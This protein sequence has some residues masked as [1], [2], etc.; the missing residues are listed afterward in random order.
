MAE[1]ERRSSCQLVLHTPV[2]AHT[3]GAH[4]KMYHARIQSTRRD[5]AQG[6][7]G[8]V[9]ATKAAMAASAAVWQQ[10]DVCRELRE[11]ERAKLELG[12]GG[13]V[14][15]STLHSWPSVWLPG[16]GLY[17]VSDGLHDVG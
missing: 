10:G 17:T 15:A 14:R 4:I 3:A 13:L 16:A 7:G 5:G 8:N 11:R 12:L 2:T 9:L 6:D 1:L